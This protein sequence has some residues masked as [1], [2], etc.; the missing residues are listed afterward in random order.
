MQRGDP[1]AGAAPCGGA[2]AREGAAGEAARLAVPR[3]AHARQRVREQV[4]RQRVH[5]RAAA[6]A[7]AA[8]PVVAHLRRGARGDRDRIPAAE[9]VVRASARREA[10]GAK[11]G[12]LVSL[13][14]STSE[15]WSTAAGKRRR[16]RGGCGSGGAARV[17]CRGERGGS[18]LRC[19]A[20]TTCLM[21]WRQWP[22][23]AG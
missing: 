3:V 20:R 19:G 23:E 12:L 10:R 13:V 17:A 14:S 8:G 18:S 21:V 9:Q 16:R 15:R 1:R 6:A 7:G 2:G 22:V 5:A 11:R 4:Q